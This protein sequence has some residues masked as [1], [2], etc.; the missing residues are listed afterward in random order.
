MD[1][2]GCE[3][4]IF[5]EKYRDESR[6][7]LAPGASTSVVQVESVARRRLGVRRLLSDLGCSVTGPEPYS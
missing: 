2:A 5:N 6:P 4:G 3:Q 1:V 7:T